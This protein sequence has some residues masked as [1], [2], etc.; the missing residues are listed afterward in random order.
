MCEKVNKVNSIMVTME[1][2]DINSFKLLYTSLVRPHIEYANQVWCPHLK[3]QIEAIVNVRQRATKQVPGL[4]TL[5][6]EEILRKLKLPTLSYRRS[7][8]DMKL[9]TLSYR[10]SR[11][12]MKLST[13][14][15]RRSRGDMKLP[16]LSYRGSRGDMKL[17]TLSYRGSRGDMKLPTLSYRRS[18]GDM[19]EMYKILTGK[20]DDD[21][22]MFITP[23]NDSYTRG[24]HLKQYK[25]RSR[26]DIRKYTFM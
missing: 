6:Y 15:Y 20:Y 24:H 21:V 9:P 14:S 12:D 18:S 19:I 23:S 16:T 7:R 1:Y 8:G 13:L 2:M 10:R 11:G 5:T 4:S 26:L 22:S 3:K 25:S 17:P